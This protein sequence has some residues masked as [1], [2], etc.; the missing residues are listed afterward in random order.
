MKKFVSGLPPDDPPPAEPL[1]DGAPLEPG[2]PLDEV[3]P[4]HV[5]APV[6]QV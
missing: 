2:E 3:P 5:P 6:M 4:V 1:L